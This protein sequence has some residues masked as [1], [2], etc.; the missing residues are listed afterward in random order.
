MKS[1]GKNKGFTLIEMI[2]VIAVFLFIVGAALGI[3]IEIVKNQKR[4]L[5]EQQFLNQISY[6][7]EYMSKALRMAKTEKGT[8]D[9]LIDRATQ[10]SG[11]HTDYMY[12][13]TRPVTRSGEIYFTGIKFINQSD[14]NSCQEFFL[15]GAGTTADPY[16]LRAT[17]S[18]VSGGTYPVVPDLDAALTPATLQFDDANPIIF[19]VNGSDGTPQASVCP[20][21]A[22]LNCGAKLNT[23]SVFQPQPRVTILMNVKISGDNQVRS[24]QTSVSRRN[25]NVAQ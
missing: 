10:G 1:L 16:I 4:I 2:I 9:C 7:E 12:L 11:N 13:L 14:D 5:A 22:P 17:R 18:S 21:G 8:E 3:F 25:L 6:V 23:A 20:D 24:I 19:S 15:A